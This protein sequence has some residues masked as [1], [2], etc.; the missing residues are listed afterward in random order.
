MPNDFSTQLSTEQQGKQIIGPMGNRGGF[1]GGLADFASGLI[2]ANVHREDQARS[3][4]NQDYQEQV[5]QGQ[6]EAAIGYLKALQTADDQ[7][8]PVQPTDNADLV[9][10]GIAAPTPVTGSP[11]PNIPGTN[12][13]STPPG[14]ENG[15]VPPD[16][17]QGAEQLRRASTA[18]AQ[19]RASQ[20]T[21]DLHLE[22]VINDAIARHPDAAAEILS[23]YHSQGFTHYLYQDVQNTL[24]AQESQ[25]AQMR[26][27][28]DAQVQYAVT[29]GLG[30]AT[31]DDYFTLAARGQHG[32]FLQAQAEANQ[33]RLDEIKTQLEIGRMTTQ[34]A[35]NETTHTAES[36]LQNAFNIADQ[37]ISPI[38]QQWATLAAGADLD[39]TIR[40][41]GMR[42]AL[43]GNIEAAHVAARAAVARA[44]GRNLQSN[45]AAVDTY[46]QGYQRMM[47]NVTSGDSSQFR[48]NM[49]ALE[50][51]RTQLHLTGRRQ[52]QMYTYLSETFGQNTVNAMFNDG[53]LSHVAPG[54]MTQLAHELAG[55]TASPDQTS[56]QI[57]LA[58]IAQL[59]RGNASLTDVPESQRAAVLGTLTPTV[60]TSNGLVAQSIANR[61]TPDFQQLSTSL[62][63]TTTVIDAITSLQHG[64]TRIGSVITA[65][66]FIGDR[67]T[68]LAIEAGINNPQTHD[69]SLA[70]MTGA[71]AGAARLLTI[72]QPQA[73]TAQDSTGVL[74][75]VYVPGHGYQVQG[76]R[77]R[78]ATYLA[79][80][81][82]QRTVPIG[83]GGR[84]GTQPDASPPRT[85]EDILRR[86]DANLQNIANALNSNINML[87][88]TRQYDSHQPLQQLPFNQAL[89]FWATGRLPSD[90][91]ARMQEQSNRPNLMNQQIDALERRISEMPSHIQANPESRVNLPQSV[92]EYQ[93]IISEIATRYGIPAGFFAAMIN[94]ESSWNPT[95]NAHDRFPNSHAFGLGQLQPATARRYGLHVEMDANGNPTANDER[96]DPRRN[97]DASARYLL[98]LYNENGHDWGRA[99]DAYSGNSHSSEARQRILSQL[100]QETPDA[101]H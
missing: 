5:R 99:L 1:L 96:R 84:L 72:L 87:A 29:H 55:F 54:V 22:N 14:F 23:F 41:D 79:N 74:R 52:L 50:A 19:G 37:N 88:N 67:N 42:Q 49:R 98:D 65:S 20:G 71:R 24:T 34:Q 97:L 90:V 62:N 78:Y 58:H 12:V 35:D 64:T 10:S 66:N 56:A 21:L 6:N 33:H 28:A 15:G 31:T 9:S 40:L 85:Y 47:D 100:P 27:S 91:A 68:R 86:N 32:M 8:N 11:L 80:T 51:T 82:A 13:A 92:V 4:S 60:R 89:D 63:G 81:A 45:L 16:V 38:I 76:D 95:A 59:L 43:T 36:V 25:Q 57:H 83:M 17:A 69:Q 3:L 73:Q 26:Q 18:V 93:P 39:Q 44:G 2:S 53:I 61:Q 77:S 94:Q 46:F 75:I 101:Q 30:S 48:A 70:L 7:L